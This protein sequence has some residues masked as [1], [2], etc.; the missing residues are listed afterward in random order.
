MT[1]PARLAISGASGRMGSALL[2]LVRDDERFELVRAIV[3][4]SSPRLGKA[5]FGDVSALRF[6]NRKCGER[7]S[8][9][10]VRHFRRTLKKTRVQIENVAR[11]SFTTRRTTKKK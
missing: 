9:S 7:T 4:S 6:N 10:F 3:S 5:A 8:A 11:I 2:G 1:R